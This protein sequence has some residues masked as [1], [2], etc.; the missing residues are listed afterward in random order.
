MQIYA[1]ALAANLLILSFVNTFA[2]PIH[3]ITRFM[4]FARPFF[5]RSGVARILAFAWAQV[6]SMPSPANSQ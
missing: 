6:H 4:K 1:R 3:F 2:G 5:S